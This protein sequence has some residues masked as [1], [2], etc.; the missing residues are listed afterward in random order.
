MTTSLWRGTANP[1]GWP[2]LVEDIQADIAIVGGGI[3]GVSLAWRLVQ[4][5]RSVV[6]L[7]ANGLGVGD[8]GNSTGNL[9]ATVSSGLHAL[10][11]K[12]GD[13]VVRQ[14][15]Q[16]R[17]EAVDWVEEHVHRLGID[18]AFRR[19]PLVRYPASANARDGIEAEFE[20]SLAAGL[21]IRREGTLPPGLPHAHGDALVLEQQAQFHP[22]AY[23]LALA[24][25]AADNGCRIFE[26]SPVIEIDRS[27]QL[28]RTE[29]GSVKAQHIVLA[30]HSP[31]GFHLMQAG[32]VPHR[33]YGLAA[34][35][36]GDSF[37]V[38][39]FYAEGSERLSV[40]G[41]DTTQGNYLVCVGQTAKTGQHDAAAAMASWKNRQGSA[42][43][44][45][46]L[47][48]AGR[49]R[50]PPSPDGLPYIGKD[51]FGSYIATGFATDGLTYG[52]LAAAIIADQ[53]LGVDNRWSELYKATRLT[54]VKS[55]KGTAEE[56]V[57]MGKALIQDYLTRRQHEQLQSL[58]PGNAAIAELEGERVAAYRDPAGRLFAVSPVCTHMKCIVHWNAVEMSWDCPCHGSRFAP[59]GSVL[60]GPA[61]APLTIKLVPDQESG[62]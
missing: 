51:A 10:R 58:A 20:A 61:L 18:C 24:R 29:R 49:H 13:D 59:D 39:I 62:T 14:V 16:S 19:C 43:A 6:L 50:T 5:G 4:A 54:A 2:L 30:T 56:V 41:L 21:A 37:P 46:R 22:L 8:T 17:A 60:S 9:Y 27:Q 44:F 32:M 35:L 34:P 53:L 23:V 38:G 12:W 42:S 26:R 55:A 33:E 31:S 40:R 47:P 45:G 11:Q 25:H 28:L 3:T 48:F 1:T 7:E 15:T 57:S 36:D 52:T